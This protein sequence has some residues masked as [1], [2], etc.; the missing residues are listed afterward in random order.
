VKVGFVGE[1]VACGDT[2]ECVIPFE[3]ANDQFDAGAIVVK[4]PEVERLQS[5]IAD[6]DLVV[7]AAQLEQRQLL[8]RL[9]G[10]EAANDH[11]AIGTCPTG[12]LVAKLGD[13]AAVSDA[14]RAR[15]PEVA[16]GDFLRR[17]FEVPDDGWDGRSSFDGNAHSAIA[18]SHAAW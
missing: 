14:V 3:L 15:Y 9:L 16:G 4:A 7:V 17:W 18:V 13:L 12:G 2:A 5:E 8:A 10:L 6:Q 11:E 1:E